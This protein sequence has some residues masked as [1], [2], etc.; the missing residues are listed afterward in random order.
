MRIDR[1]RSLQNQFATA[2]CPADFIRRVIKCARAQGPTRGGFSDGIDLALRIQDDLSRAYFAAT[3]EDLAKKYLCLFERVRSRGIR[4]GCAETAQALRWMLANP[5]ES[6][7]C[8][9]IW[10]QLFPEKTSPKKGAQA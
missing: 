1:T 4:W 6:P 8:P 2:R 3:G 7:T 5:G 10:P 9:K